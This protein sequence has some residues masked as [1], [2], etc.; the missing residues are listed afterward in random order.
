MYLHLSHGANILQHNSLEIH[1]YVLILGPG[2]VP[3][4]PIL[5]SSV[6]VEFYLLFFFIQKCFLLQ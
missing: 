1:A 3:Y 4:I 2:F 5:V 6:H